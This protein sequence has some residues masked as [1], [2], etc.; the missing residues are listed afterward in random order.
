MSSKRTIRAADMVKDIRSGLTDPELMD[1]H[2]LSSEGLRNVFRKLLEAEAISPDEIYGRPP[3]ADEIVDFGASYRIVTRYELDV[4][5]PVHELDN[6]D[7]KGVIRDMSVNGVGI[8]GI[9]A[10]VD[11]IKSFVIPAGQF[12]GVEQVEFEAI[13]RWTRTEKIGGECSSGFE[14]LNVMKG[15]LKDLEMVIR[16]MP[17]EDRVALQDQV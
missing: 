5:L 12:L 14:V 6:R 9:D 4:P 3:S 17:L 16:S 1:K 10:S 7:I 2:Q 15:S 13:C 11:E 8:R